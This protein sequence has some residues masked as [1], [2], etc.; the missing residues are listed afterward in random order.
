M[1]GEVRRGVVRI[2][3]NY[4]RLLANV[5]IGLVLVRL[6]L[7]G[8]GPEGYGLYSLLF[9]T[10]GFAQMFREVVRYSMNRELGVAYHDPDPDVFP[11]VFNSAFVLSAVLAVL[12]GLLFVALIFVVP[13]LNVPAD[14]VAPAQW[15]IVANGIYISMMV[16]LAPHFNMFVVSERMPL[17]NFWLFTE[18]LC[19]LAA[20]VVLFVVLGI[21][22][23]GRGLLLF[24]LVSSALA[25][26]SL[27]CAVAT[28]I[29]LDRRLVPHP[30]RTS[31]ACVRSILTTGGWNA[32]VVTAA[33]MH[34]RLDQLLMNAL[35]LLANSFFGVAMQLAN[36]GRMITVGMTDGLDAVSARLHTTGREGALRELLRHSTRLHAFVALPAGAVIILLAEPIVAVWLHGVDRVPASFFPIVASIV[37]VIAIGTMARAIADGWTRLLYGAGFVSRVAPLAVIGGLLN[38]LIALVM[39]LVLPASSGGS[40]LSVLHGPAIAFAASYSIVHLIALPVVVARCIG[41]R[42][43]EVVGPL[44]RPTV[45]TAIAAA[46]LLIVD[47][48]V[49][50]LGFWGLLLAGV[51]FGVTYAVCVWIMVLSGEERSI[52]TKSL[53]RLKPNRVFGG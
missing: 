39:F 10:I 16:L 51:A 33:N 21:S 41:V 43:T 28:I 25:T 20:A 44:G 40:S 17:A 19:Y 50:G 3:T 14:L 48:Q 4:G 45:A 37:R 29:R 53:S 47:T 24:G 12:A 11:R 52:L 5:L 22:D 34:I 18:R 23:P 6:L 31:R 38:P 32:V 42:Y 9:S 27:W 35:G 30:A 26:V 7:G 46:A 15:F 36:Y 49:R 8:L 2:A 1:T 13:L